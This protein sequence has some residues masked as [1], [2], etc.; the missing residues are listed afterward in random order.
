MST[1][2]PPRS[3][4]PWTFCAAVL[5]T[6]LEASHFAV[7]GPSQS[8][9][10]EHRTSTGC[11]LTGS[12][13]GPAR[14][15]VNGA[16]GEGWDCTPASQSASRGVPHPRESTHGQTG[17]PPSPQPRETSRR[18]LTIRSGREPSPPHPQQ[19]LHRSCQ[20]RIAWRL[21]SSQTQFT[22]ESAWCRAMALDKS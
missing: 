7:F 10:L 11:A 20:A 17:T 5:H 18:R 1:Q 6:N 2:A 15:V 16:N 13:D 9:I 19:V 14:C 3:F 12:A 21:P 4:D 22:G 8:Q